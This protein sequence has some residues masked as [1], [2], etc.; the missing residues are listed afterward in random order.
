MDFD[1]L[2]LRK[3][4]YADFGA[5]MIE[6]S[7]DELDR[8]SAV[9]LRDRGRWAPRL[10]ILLVF[11]AA[12]AVGSVVLRGF[13]ATAPSETAPASVSDLE[14]SQQEVVDQLQALQEALRQQRAETRKLSDEVAALSGRLDALQQSFAS[15][16]VPVSKPD[17]PKPKRPG[18]PSTTQPPQSPRQ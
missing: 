2:L 10:F 11:L 12:L 6:Y 9:A 17:A 1:P 13:Y 8:D 5:P 4:I 18:A 15:A 16:P 14:A 3:P 7:H